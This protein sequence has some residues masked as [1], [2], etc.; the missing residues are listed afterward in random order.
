MSTCPRYTHKHPRWVLALE[1]RTRLLGTLNLAVAL[2]GK[3]CG[4]GTCERPRRWFIGRHRF[5]RASRNEGR[6]FLRIKIT[7]GA[8]REP[9]FVRQVS[10]D[11]RKP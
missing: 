8:L 9:V 11:R 2:R 10:L 6:H 1:T 5:G 4:W 3:S 7:K